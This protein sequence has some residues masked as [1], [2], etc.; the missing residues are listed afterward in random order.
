MLE[1]KNVILRLVAESDIDELLTLANQYTEKGEFVGPGFFV[2]TSFRKAFAENGWWQDDQGMMLATDKENRIL[3]T[4]VFF[5]G[6]RH[7][8]GYEVGYTILRREDWGKGLASETLRIFSAYLFEL[9]PIARL[10][11]K[12]IKGNVASRRVAEKCGYRLEAPSGSSASAAERTTTMKS[13][14]YS[15]RIALRWPRC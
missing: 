4:V 11:V 12:M 10:H 7:E 9:K 5:Q 6:M 8:A 2:E 14:R 1:G 3:G 13:S 15:G